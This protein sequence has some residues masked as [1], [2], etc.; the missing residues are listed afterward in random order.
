MNEDR[1]SPTESKRGI[2]ETP[3][4]S[5]DL[6]AWPP[7]STWSWQAF[8]QGGPARSGQIRPGSRDLQL[9]FQHRFARNWMACAL[10]W[11][12]SRRQMFCRPKKTRKYSKTMNAS[13]C[14]DFV[15]FVPYLTDF[16]IFERSLAWCSQ[17]ALSGMRRTWNGGH[18]GHGM[19]RHATA[20]AATG[21]FSL[22]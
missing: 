12:P 1:R 18:S 20:T 4:A 11:L 14:S 9:Q 3:V 10:N 17:N 21:R 5:E 7:C 15:C 8:E 16:V 19:P 6:H 22:F 2:D 13:L